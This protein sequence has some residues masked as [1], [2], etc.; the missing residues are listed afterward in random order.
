M[1]FIAKY[2]NNC[3]PPILLAIEIHKHNVPQKNIFFILHSNINHGNIQGVLAASE[4]VTR[5]FAARGFFWDID[6]EK[7]AF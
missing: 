5:E 2:C 6:I 4:F 3:Y 1:V 7:I